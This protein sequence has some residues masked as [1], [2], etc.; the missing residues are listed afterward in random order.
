LLGWEAHKEEGT[1]TGYIAADGL[2]AGGFPEEMDYHLFRALAAFARAAPAIRGSRLYFIIVI[3]NYIFI[4]NFLRF[5]V[6][7]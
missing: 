2:A 5:F 6:F 1:E 4:C 7:P 3:V